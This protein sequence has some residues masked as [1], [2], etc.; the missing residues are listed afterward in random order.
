MPAIIESELKKQIKSRD[1]SNVYLI[2]GNE[3]YLKHHYFNLLIKKAVDDT[4]KDFNLHIFQS[5]SDVEEITLAAEAM[6]MMSERTCVAIKDLKLS[7]LGEN[8]RKDLVSFISDIPETCVVIIG[9]LTTEAEGKGW[10]E[11]LSACEKYGNSIRLDKMSRNDLIKYVIKGA[12][13]RGCTIDNR[14]AD[15]F[16][17]LVGDD[18]TAI[19]NELEK[20]CAN[21]GG[22]TISR[23][24][25]DAVT[26]KN[27]EVK[28]FE[29]S[30]NLVTGN[31]DK[32]F[33][34]LDSLLKQREEPISILGTIIMC[35]V[36]MY[37]AKVA[38]TGGHRPEE[39][40]KVFNYGKSDFRLRNGA[41]NASKMSLGMLRESIEILARADENLK[42][43][44]IDQR[45]ILEETMI[46]LFLIAN[47]EKVC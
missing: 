17:S 18:L 19:L 21:A 7:D 38:S 3:S 14:V 24:N 31:C 16:I 2:Y 27:T 10:K 30:K 4:F 5:P 44:S 20:L 41:K 26:V 8:G 6:P 29:L 36:D 22:G 12:S 45:L 25:V 15:Y 40:L 13:S 39:L 47:G 34:I 33:S 42:S 11:L 46:K 28:I 37:R 9:F 1:F 23:A 35:Y 32:A 43:T